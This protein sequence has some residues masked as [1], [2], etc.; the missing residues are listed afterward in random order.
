MGAYRVSGDGFSGTVL[1][2]DRSK[3]RFYWL[4]GGAATDDVQQVVVRQ[5]PI[6]VL[7]LGLVEPIPKARTMY[8]SADGVLPMVYLQGFA[9]K[10]VRVALNRDGLGERLAEEAGE[11]LPQVK[12]MQP[13]AVDWVESLRVG[14]ARSIRAG[15]QGRA[16]TTQLE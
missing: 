7:A 8:L 14:R 3:G 16:N 9:A 13:E 2:S 12:Q 6:D 1:G 5:T 10:R 15:V 11:E 4:R